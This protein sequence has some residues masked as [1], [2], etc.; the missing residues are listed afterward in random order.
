METDSNSAPAAA[1]GA[2]GAGLQHPSGSMRA[3]DL[4]ARDHVGRARYTELPRVVKASN[5]FLSCRARI[6]FQLA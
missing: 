5:P 3:S 4:P 6:A 2:T 1:E